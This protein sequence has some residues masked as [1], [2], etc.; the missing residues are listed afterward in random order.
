MVGVALNIDPSLPRWEFVPATYLWA[1]LG[2]GTIFFGTGLAMAMVS[3][4]PRYRKTFWKHDTL[5]AYISRIW[6]TRVTGPI[7]MGNTAD[8]ARAQILIAWNSRYWCVAALIRTHQR[9]LRILELL[10]TLL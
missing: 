1:V 10:L 2:F 8:A 7:G 5:R 6:H 4:P 3:M 9:L